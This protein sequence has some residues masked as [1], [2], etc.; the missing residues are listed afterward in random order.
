MAKESKE[1]K[2]DEPWMLGPL[3]FPIGP[4]IHKGAKELRSNVARDGCS[5]YI[6][7]E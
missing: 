5:T 7:L 1:V 2:R 6:Y 3:F 4:R